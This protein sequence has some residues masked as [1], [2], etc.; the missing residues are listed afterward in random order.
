LNLVKALWSRE[1]RDISDKE[2]QDFYEYLTG[3]FE[4]YQYRF[5]FAS[6]VPLQLKSILYI[7]KNHEEKFGAFQ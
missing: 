1:K 3:K 6:E 2:Y 7:P 5:H 4:K